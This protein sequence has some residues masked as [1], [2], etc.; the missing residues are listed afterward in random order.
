MLDLK[1]SSDTKILFFMTYDEPFLT[2]AK[3]IANLNNLSIKLC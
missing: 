3:T 2:N 1:K